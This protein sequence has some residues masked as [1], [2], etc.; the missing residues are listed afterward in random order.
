MPKTRILIKKRQQ[1][2]QYYT[3]Q[4]VDGV[5]LDMVLIPAGQFWMGSPEGEL[6]REE[7]HLVTVPEFFMGRYP[8]TQGQWK[9]VVDNTKPV[10]KDLNPEPSRFSEFEDIDWDQDKQVKL[11]KAL[12]GIY[13]RY[14]DLEVF[15]NEALDKNLASLVPP[16]N[17]S[18]VAF[19]LI[20]WAQNSGRLNTLFK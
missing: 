10:G 19:E 20:R 17:P 7:Q 16:E 6:E 4:L 18:A 8:V 13:P 12:M 3:E 5:G 14:S 2:V 1:A 15:V 9:A 11:R